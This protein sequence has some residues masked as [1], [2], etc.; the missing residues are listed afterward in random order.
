M[1]VAGD[2]LTK[3][4]VK[5]GTTIAAI[6]ALNGLTSDTVQLGRVLLIP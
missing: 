2:N 6:K 3:I 1:V 5:F 4:A